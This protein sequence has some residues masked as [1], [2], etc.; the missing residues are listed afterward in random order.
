MPSTLRVL[1]LV[2]V[3]ALAPAPAE[4]QS[5]R[6][7]V[8]LA[9]DRGVEHLIGAQLVDGSWYDHQPTFR[10]GMTALALYALVECDVPPEHPAIQRATAFLLAIEP[11][12]TYEMAV[13]TIAFL[14]LVPSLADRAL[15]KRLEERVAKYVDLLVSY[16]DTGGGYGYPEPDIDL[17]NTQYAAMAL[18]NAALAGH[19]VP[20]KVWKGIAEYTI[21]LQEDE[22]KGSMPKAGV[23]YR[24]DFSPSGSM[25]AAAV[26]TL[27][28]C[29]EQQ[30]RP[31]GTWSRHQDAALAWLADK[32]VVND[33]PGQPGAWRYYYL[34][35]IERVGSM[36]GTSTIGTHAWYEE[37]ATYLVGEQQGGGD[38]WNLPDTCFALLFL[39]RATA[40]STGAGDRALAQRTFGSDDPAAS[41][42]LRAFGENPLRIWTSSFGQAELDA[43]GVDRPGLGRTLDVLLCEYWLD[44]G[45]GIDAPQLLARFDESA[46]DPRL[47]FEHLFPGRGTYT[48]RATYTIADANAADGRLVFDSA[49]LSIEVRREDQD[50]LVRIARGLELNQLRNVEVRVRAS[51]WIDDNRGPHLV[52]DGIHSVGW[53]SAAVDTDPFVSLAWNEYLKVAEVRVAHLQAPNAPESVLP[54]EI[55]LTL[56]GREEF[57]LELPNS[58]SE[59]GVL[60]LGGTKKVR[61][62]RIDVISV[63]EGEAGAIR[64]VGLGEIELR[65]VEEP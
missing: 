32:F 57:T 50:A 48:L 29:N 17:S 5:L 1:A 8:N 18:R 21:S 9:I 39:K 11:V 31:V 46:S 38:W 12:K 25:T 51:T 23:R 62:L 47:S 26:A 43:F 44:E 40:P 63:H 37:G 3:A 52:C 4:A 7:Q 53:M 19:E 30:K 36:L 41:A 28:I 13:T 35:T 59:I 15:A 42:S 33:N 2:A 64:P 22:V 54:R 56:N 60:K 58:R 24:P 65:A 34:Y 45:P 27:H 61:S 14:E 6:E 20:A 55:K 16:Q 10:A 49:P